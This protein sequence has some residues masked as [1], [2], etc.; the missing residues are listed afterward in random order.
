LIARVDATIVRA[1]LLPATMKLLGEWNWY[2]PR[3]LQ[4]LPRFAAEPHR[5][6]LREPSPR[7][8]PEPARE[9]TPV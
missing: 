4:G 1:V 8:E 7:E 9:V 2:L 5:R 6:P 3:W